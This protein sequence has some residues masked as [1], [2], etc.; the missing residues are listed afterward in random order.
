MSIFQDF[1]TLGHAADQ[2]EFNMV[3]EEQGNTYFMSS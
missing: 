1:L 2:T 3:L